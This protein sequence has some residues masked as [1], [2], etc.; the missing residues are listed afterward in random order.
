MGSQLSVSAVAGKGPGMAARARRLRWHAGLVA[1]AA[2]PLGLCTLAALPAAPAPGL[3][4][5]AVFHVGVDPRG[6]AVSP[7]GRRLYVVNSYQ[8]N[9]PA[10]SVSVLAAATGAVIATI[11]V[12][13]DPQQVALSPDGTHAYVT[14]FGDGTVSA[15]DAGT[16]RVMATLQATGHPSGLAVSRDGTR[17]FVGDTLAGTVSVLHPLSSP[18]TAAV[19]EKTG[20][21][22]E[23]VALSSDD[24]RLYVTDPAGHSVN[25]L[26]AGSG[27]VLGRIDVGGTARQIA[28][29]PDGRRA[30][31]TVGSGTVA[32]I[33]TATRKVLTHVP[34]A[35]GSSPWAVAV[36]PDGASIYVT[37]LI[38]GGSVSVIDAA[39]DRVV[40]TRR[41]WLPDGVAAGP[42][43]RRVYVTNDLY[44]G[45]VWVLRGLPRGRR[46]R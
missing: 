46:S 42:G 43:G 18:A 8:G 23:G 32:V 11:P 4:R 38:H 20:G 26:D 6:V 33:C 22:A 44:A 21:D 9:G 34:L 19:T 29:S 15:I 7:D 40:A 28:M 37:S 24:R 36:S 35:A 2:L 1:A 31:V 45:T 10:G 13:P 16:D 3:S 14:N 41:A 12:G 30:Y 25:V 5:I 17:V 27:A 39:S